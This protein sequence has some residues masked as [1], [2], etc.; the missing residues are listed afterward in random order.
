MN[1][2]ESVYSPPKSE[3]LTSN[4]GDI[5]GNGKFV[6]YNSDIDWPA[7]CY[8]CNQATDGKKN[9]TLTHLNPWFYLSILISPLLLIILGLIFQKRFK[10][11]LPICDEHLQKRQKHV[12]VNWGITAAMVLAF[13]L[14]IGLEVNALIIAAVVLMLVLVLSLVIGRLIYVARRKDQQLWVR[15]AGPE[16]IDSLPPYQD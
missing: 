14:G 8:K 15:G 12:K 1:Q 10:L 4:E 9:I 16:F 5:F 11:D 7:R 13:G 6:V 2:E 3:V